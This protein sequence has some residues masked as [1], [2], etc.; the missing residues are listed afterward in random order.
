MNLVNKPTSIGLLLS[1][2][3]L[4]GCSPIKT[5]VT[6]QYTLDI[7]AHKK[8][9]HQRLNYSLLISK[10]EAMAGYQTEQMLYVQKPFTLEPFAKNAWASPPAAMLYPILVQ[11]IQGSHVFRAITSSPFADKTDYRLDTQLLTLNQNFLSKQSTLNFTAKIAITRVADNHVLASRLIVKRIPCS[12]NTPLGG[13]IAANQASSA[14]A[15][16]TLDF[17]VTQVQ[18][19]IT[20]KKT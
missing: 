13:V 1:F 16:D 19:D 14:F 15:K 2:A 7:P 11:H 9:S 5:P 8:S 18:R 10:P 4:A 20:H 17:A 3:V 12:S 6:H